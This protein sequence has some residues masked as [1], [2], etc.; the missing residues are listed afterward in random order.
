[1]RG[2]AIIIPF[3]VP[4]IDPTVYCLK[5]HECGL[6]SIQIDLISYK[7]KITFQRFCK[8][9]AFSR[10]CSFHWWMCQELTSIHQMH[11]PA[12]APGVRD[13]QVTREKELERA[14][15]WFNYQVV[16]PEWL[17]QKNIQRNTAKWLAPQGQLVRIVSSMVFQE[18][19]WNAEVFQET[20]KRLSQCD[21]VT[22]EK[23]TFNI[24]F[25]TISE[26]MLRWVILACDPRR[27]LRV[28]K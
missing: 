16:S 20:L 8:L 6:T 21:N 18:H 17:A 10:L 15:W 1:M 28:D 25:V 9:L 7:M 27:S 14:N 3:T 23:C 11:C 22:R 19:D 26:W 5:Y 13:H 24:F 2:D 12:Q 4:R